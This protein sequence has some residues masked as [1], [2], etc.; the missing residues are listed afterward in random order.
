MTA[1]DLIDYIHV[2]NY[3]SFDLAVKID[4]KWVPVED[5]W[6]I[7]GTIKISANNEEDS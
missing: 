5:A 6:G 2:N 3:E 7:N 4:G 1:Q